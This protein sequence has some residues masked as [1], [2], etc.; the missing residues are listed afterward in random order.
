MGRGGPMERVSYSLMV[1]A[2]LIFSCIVPNNTFCAESTDTTP[3]LSLWTAN[4]L[5]C[6][7]SE[8]KFGKRVP[9]D[10]RP[11]VRLRPEHMLAP[12][13][14]KEI[15]TI[16]RV[17]PSK[18]QKVI[19]LTFDLC[20]LT[21]QKAGYDYPVVEY[22]R[23]QRIRATFF[24]GGKWM[25]SHP[26]R[27]LQLLADPLFE[28]GNHAWT[29]GNFGVMPVKGLED[30]ILWTQAQYELLRDELKKRAEVWGLGHR[31][32]KIPP[33]PALFRLPYG[34]CRDESLKLLAQHGLKVVQ[35]DVVAEETGPAASS[36][37]L[38][39]AVEASHWAI[40]PGSIVLFHAN[41]ATP[42]TFGI[43]E[44]L[45]PQL[46]QDGYQFVTVT[47]LLTLGTP[48]RTM[49]GY[50]VHPGDNR[51]YDKMFGDGT[52]HVNAPDRSKQ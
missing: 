32:D 8:L 10:R 41:G 23:E 6:S 13:P 50:F 31:V 43:L 9:P 11:P 12:R 52:V 16:R 28:I 1:M 34:R 39:A 27:T 17:N 51:Q 35:W 49:D 42:R 19:S 25:Q 21:D 44:R 38:D 5:R 7:P 48:E 14:D 37:V 15:G 24:A 2:I 46:K 3:L 4:D 30:Q 18:G 47:E 26:K 33:V 20:E 40:R 29:H 36:A 22:L 45:V